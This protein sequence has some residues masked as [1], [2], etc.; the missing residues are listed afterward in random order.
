[1]PSARSGRARRRPSHAERGGEG[2]RHGERRGQQQHQKGS[3]DARW[4]DA[5]HR[6]VGSHERRAQDE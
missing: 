1:M 4:R 5:D 2:E 3:D 6:Q